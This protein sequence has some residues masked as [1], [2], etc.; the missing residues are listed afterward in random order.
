LQLNGKAFAGHR[1]MFNN[2]N[3]F[4]DAMR[5]LDAEFAKAQIPFRV[6]E[7]RAV[8]EMCRRSG[9]QFS[10]PDTTLDEDREPSPGVFYGRDLIVRVRRWYR[11]RL[12]GMHFDASR[13]LRVA[14]I[15]QNDPWS[16][17][18]PVF[19]GTLPVTCDP[20]VSEPS[21][22]GARINIPDH[23]DNLPEGI[24]ASVTS[25]EWRSTTRVFALAVDAAEILRWGDNNPLMRQAFLDLEATVFH[26]TRDPRNLGEARWSSLQVAEKALK[27]IAEARNVPYPRGR[28]GHILSKVADAVQAGGPLQID[29]NL[30]SK[31]QCEADVRYGKPPVSLKEAVAAHHAVLSLLASLKHQVLA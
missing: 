5:T 3:D 7:L 21:G 15:L 4:D 31:I 28:D 2:E 25:E 19:F 6:R 16:L 17:R 29:A 27:T 14:V 30:L 26:L 24:R 18:V 11:Q 12:A 13:L 20:V 22:H 8:V 9:Q 23:F 10:L 1:I